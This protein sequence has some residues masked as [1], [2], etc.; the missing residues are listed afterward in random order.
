M[1][2]ALHWLTF[3]RHSQCQMQNNLL[4]GL[5]C[6]IQKFTEVLGHC[7]LYCWLFG[8]PKLCGE[9]DAHMCPIHQL[10]SICHVISDSNEQLVVIAVIVSKQ[11]LSKLV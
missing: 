5:P 9:T 11:G 8:V 3:Q 6:L 7:I 4:I 2:T 10:E 1:T